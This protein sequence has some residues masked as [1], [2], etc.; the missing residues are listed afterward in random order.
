M[1]LQSIR[2]VGIGPFDDLVFRPVDADGAPRKVVLVLGGAGVGKT[3]L[4]SVIATTRPGHAIA[5]SRS[6]TGDPH[7]HS[8]A[9]A[10]WMLGDDDKARPHPLRVMSPNAVLDEPE[11]MVQLRKRE[12]VLFDRK[13]AERGFALV[14]FSAVRWFSRSP[15]VVSTPE[16]TIFRYDVRA[17]WS[18]DDATRA[19]LARETKLVLSYGAVGAALVEQKACQETPSAMMAVQFDCAV[20]EVVDLLGRL[21]GF[22]YVGP[23]PV[24]LEPM[25][26]KSGGSGVDFDNLPTSARHLIAFGALTVRALQGA[27]PGSDPRNAEGVVLIDNIAMHQDQKAQE[28]LIPTLRE[29]L[30]RVQWVMTT[31]SAAVAAGCDVSETFALRRM[32]TSGGVELHEGPLA[33]L[34]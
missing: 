11:D 18:F 20:R 22:R 24:S 28:E 3:T 2:V 31:S 9:V 34:H 15:V 6:R 29:A 25:F 12:Q 8:F 30:P 27:Y 19:D 16:R 14:A 33:T 32:P 17:P 7:R 23:D 10:E 5:Q 1:L 4:L 13:S 26:E 21:A